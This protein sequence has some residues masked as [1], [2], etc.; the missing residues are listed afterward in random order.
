MDEHIAAKCISHPLRRRILD[1][2]ASRPISPN[3]LAVAL[4]E[5][6]TNV[7]YHVRQL[8]ELGAIELVDA[9][10]RR[11]ALEHYYRCAVRIPPI[12]VAADERFRDWTA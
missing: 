9:K 1:L 5:P 10:P 2:L 6:L 12:Q 11:G 4:D 3:A 8:A 7:S